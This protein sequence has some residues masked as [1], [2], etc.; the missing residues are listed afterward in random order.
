MICLSHTLWHR[1][2]AVVLATFGLATFGLVECAVGDDVW[3]GTGG[4]GRGIYHAT[5]DAECGSLSTPRL[6]NDAMT[7]PGF[8]ALHP[9]LPVIY[10][11]G[12]VDGEP[13]VAAFEISED[14]SGATLSL[15][16]SV[17][18]GAA[19]PCHVAV[20]P[21]GRMVGTVQYSGG[22]VATFAVGEDG[23]LTRRT[24]LHDHGPGSGVVAGR[25]N[26]AHP[27]WIGFSPDG[28]H[29]LVPD[30]GMDKIVVYSVDSDD[31][32]LT[33]RTA[34][35]AIPGGGPRHMKFSA[36]GDRIYALN[37][38]DLSVTVFD[39]DADTG[40]MEAVQT[41]A[42][43]PKERLADEEFASASEIRV[44]PAGHHVYAANRGH[45]TIT[46]MAV[47]PDGRLS[48][49]EREPIRGATPRN[50]NLHPSGRWL[51]AAG[52]DSNTLAVFA[53]RQDGELVY[54]RQ[55]VNTPGPICVLFG[56]DRN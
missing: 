3:I 55:T 39:Y 16:G 45:D 35:E 1:T 51:I 28:R 41:I 13:A 37:E 24:G 4:G 15:M 17:P 2:A 49:V 38:L 18:I 47:G 5:I 36:S 14:D 54:H 30:L 22:S 9:K 50:F 29:A 46:V 6:V 42:T 56:R 32:T 23:N 7:G 8:L 44:S 21:D 48:I 27:H 34:A 25:Q 19:G 12:S 53:V 33:P 11:V 10:A 20:H 40:A 52:Q 31:A 26:E 43:V